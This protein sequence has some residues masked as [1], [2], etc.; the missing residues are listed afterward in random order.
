LNEPYSLAPIELYPTRREVENAN[1]YKLKSLKEETHKYETTDWFKSGAVETVKRLKK[2][3]DGQCQAPFMLELKKGAQVML[4][5][6]LDHNI[7]LFNGTLGIVAGFDSSDSP[8]VAF[9]VAGSP[10]PVQIAVK[11]D[12]WDILENGK[13]V[14]VRSQI[15]LILAW[16]MSI[17]KAQGQTIP[18]LKLDLSRSFEA[19]Q[20]HVA[21]S[22]AV[23]LETVEMKGFHP[24]KVQVN[25]KVAE[26]CATLKT[27]ENS[28]Q[29]ENDK[30]SVEEEDDCEIIV[31]D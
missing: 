11:Q 15:P 22:R 30:S 29:V 17:H 2:A 31:L 27:I 16:A 26:F 21:L 1:I 24:A 25:A 13:R 6:N 28:N 3:L 9:K 5:K 18:V 7:G 8:I 12:D 4:L 10:H 20:V 19:G 14:A 23:S